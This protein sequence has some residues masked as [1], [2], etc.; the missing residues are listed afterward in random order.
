MTAL[1]LRNPTVGELLGPALDNPDVMVEF[2]SLDHADRYWCL[3][4]K[5]L[6][7]DNYSVAVEFGEVKVVAF[8]NGDLVEMPPNW[9]VIW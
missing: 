3:W 6:G 7:Y 1:N 4:Q 5:E 8:K 2:V 9:S